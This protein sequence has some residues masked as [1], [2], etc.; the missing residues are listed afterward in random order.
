LREYV[1]PHDGI[2]VGRSVNPVGPSGARI[3]H[4][5]MPA[6]PDHPFRSRDPTGAA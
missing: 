3:L 4:L 2:V 5:G 1:A 6:A